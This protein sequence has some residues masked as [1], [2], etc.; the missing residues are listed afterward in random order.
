MMIC[1]DDVVFFDADKI[2]SRHANIITALFQ[3]IGLWCAVDFIGR[4]LC[5]L[6]DKTQDWMAACRNNHC[7][8]DDAKLSPKKSWHSQRR[9]V[10]GP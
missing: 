10:L 5:D 8:S 7:K 4:F 9:P 6:G 1:A 2:V 3:K